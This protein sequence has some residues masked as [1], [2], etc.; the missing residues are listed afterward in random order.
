[1]KGT[2]AFLIPFFLFQFSPFEV[3]AVPAQS[4]VD[5]RNL[6]AQGEYTRALALS[7]KKLEKNP[8]QIALVLDVSSSYLQ[9]GQRDAALRVLFKAYQEQKQK[10]DSPGALKVLMERIRLASRMF[11]KSTA[12][13]RY[14]EGLNFLW[15]KKFEDAEARLEKALDLEKDNV[16]ILLRMGQA[17]VML[18]DFEAGLEK[19]RQ[20]KE[21]DP[22]EPEIRLWLGRAL[23]KKNKLQEAVGE[24]KFAFESMKG[25]E[26]APTW[27]ADVLHQAGQTDRALR[28][29]RST[30]DKHPDFVLAWIQLYDMS[31]LRTRDTYLKNA[32][33]RLEAYVQQSP[34]EG[35]LG[36]LPFDIVQIQSQIEQRTSLQ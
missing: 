14:Q 29:V 22:F 1:M 5:Y 2:K 18:N 19:L 9:S 24:L 36:I 12:F 4:T 30:L 34:Q 6:M 8:H 26:L 28:I 10:S 3:M 16:E 27:Y 20:A 33:E 31:S 25:S 21:L 13:E 35:E 23:A 11:L 7:L 17:E 15:M 32:R